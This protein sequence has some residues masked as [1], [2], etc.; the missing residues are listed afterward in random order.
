MPNDK[1]KELENKLR[2][3]LKKEAIKKVPLD[4]KLKPPPKGGKKK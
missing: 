1:D 2:K 3:A 4:K